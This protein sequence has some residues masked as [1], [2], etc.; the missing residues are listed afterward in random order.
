[1]RFRRSAAGFALLTSMTL[2]LAG[3][4]VRIVPAVGSGASP[5]PSAPSE[6][7]ALDVLR[8][9]T[10]ET[11]R[12]AY[13]FTMAVGEGTA[14]GAADP[15][16]GNGRFNVTFVSPEDR[17]KVTFNILSVDNQAW[18]KVDLGRVAS[19]PDAPKLPKQWMLL[20][21]SKLENPDD[22]DFRQ[23]DP[24]D[25]AVVFGAIVDVKRAGERRYEGTVDLTEAT[26]A[27]LVD[28]PHV[29]A[30]AGRASSI[31]FS[32]TIDDRERLTSLEIKVPA[33]GEHE[34]TTWKGT[35]LDYGAAITLNKPKPGEVVPA[36]A[37]A[38]KLFNG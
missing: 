29:K 13:K 8:T 5:T 30:L 7:P 9:S 2:A 38:Y 34:A 26:D 6:R 15:S 33:A 31:P 4:G 20:D 19:L 25:A 21:K 11:G 16:T 28:E 32:V 12:T 22:V 36:T 18:L 14:E 17:L 1:M 23:G 27:F 3:C 37:D 35:Y 24:M 10:G